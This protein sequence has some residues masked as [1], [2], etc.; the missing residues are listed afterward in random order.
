MKILF[1]HPN[2]PGQ[3]KH[4]ARIAAENPKNEVVFITLQR[5]NISIP[6]VRK[7]EYVC[8]REPDTGCHQY[9]ISMERAVL[10]AQEVWRVCKQLKSEG[11]VPDVIVGH[12]G[13]GDGLFLKDIFHGVPILC[14]MEFYYSA[15]ASDIGF[16]KEFEEEGY[17]TVDDVARIRMKNALHLFNLADTDW[18]ITPTYF[19]LDRHPEPFHKKISVLHDG[20]DS[21]AVKPDPRATFTI[22]KKNLTFKAGDEVITYISRNFE[23]YRGIHTFM[24]AANIVLKE[25]PNAHII[26]VGGDGVSYGK[27][28][29]EGKTYR[30]ML[31]D[32]LKPDMSRIHAV[33]YLDYEEMLKVL[34][35]SAAHVYLTVPF[36]L[37]WSMMEAMSAGC[38]MVCSDTLP[39]REVLTHEKNGLMVDFF[40]PEDVA[41][42]I[43]WGLENKEQAREIRANARQTILDQYALNKVLPLHMQLINDL[44]DRQLPPAA[45]AKIRAFN[46][47]RHYAEK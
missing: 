46:K 26:M 24:R 30:H 22:P 43:I 36:V 42:K 15:Y 4:L 18:G 10:R 19:Q 41:K 21:D 17:P 44:A 9:L 13:W 1:L 12:F 40:S 8:T 45:D 29:P 31:L 7:I 25:R 3:Y 6:N 14:F 16:M 23:P 28:P 39:V 20:I 33:G 38:L 32:E 5:P 34:H 35:I 2:M 37:S 47:R 27:K 11:F